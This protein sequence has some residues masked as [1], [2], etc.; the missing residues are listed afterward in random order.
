MKSDKLHEGIK[1]PYVYK[2]YFRAS[3]GKLFAEEV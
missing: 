1:L 2:L 3:E